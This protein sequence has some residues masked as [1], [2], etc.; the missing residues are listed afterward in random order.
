MRQYIAVHMLES[1]Y[2]FIF[3]AIMQNRSAECK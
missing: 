2:K 1:K 3:S